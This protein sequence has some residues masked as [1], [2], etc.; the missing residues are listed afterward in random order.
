MKTLR[1]FLRRYG[2]V[3]TAGLLGLAAFLTVFGAEP[4]RVTGTAWLYNT[5]RSDIT[6]HYT[7][8]MF[9]R[10]SEWSLPLGTATDL[11][12]PDGVSISYTDS[13]PIVSIFFKLLSPLLPERFQFFGI[14]AA[15]CFAMQ[16]AFAAILL[17]ISLRIKSSRTS[18]VCF[19]ASPPP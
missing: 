2:Y 12:T 13:I 7:G 17:S 11:G 16:G 18:A 8:W 14:Y 5:D 3:I 9:F 10:N 1:N 4:L 19:S 6:Q 15:F